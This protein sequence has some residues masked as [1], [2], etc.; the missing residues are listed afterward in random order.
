MFSLFFEILARNRKF[1]RIPSDYHWIDICRGR[2]EGGGGIVGARESH[3][4][5]GSEPFNVQTG[6]EGG[7]S[8]KVTMICVKCFK[9][10]FW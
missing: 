8:Y 4:A 1:R 10:H 6:N 3:R 5:T 7:L 2:D 9:L